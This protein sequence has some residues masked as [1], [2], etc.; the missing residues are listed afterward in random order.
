M[1]QKPSTP[2]SRYV[3]TTTT[4]FLLT[5]KRSSSA[6]KQKATANREFIHCPS[7]AENQSTIPKKRL[8]TGIVGRRTEKLSRSVASATANSTSTPFPL[9]AEKKRASPPP[10]VS[11]TARITPRTANGS[12]STPIALAKCTS[13]E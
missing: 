2:A 4:A 11:T 8:R 6:T 13:G 9:V 12:I 5:A 3:A 10:K 7:P 1:A